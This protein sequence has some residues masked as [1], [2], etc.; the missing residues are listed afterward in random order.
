MTA[1]GVTGGSGLV[2]GAEEYWGGLQEHA[3]GF[4]ERQRC[5]ILVPRGMQRIG[6][7]PVSLCCLF[8]SFEAGSSISI[9]K[10]LVEKKKNKFKTHS[11]WHIQSWYFPL[12]LNRLGCCQ[13]CICSTCFPRCQ[14]AS[15]TIDEKG[16]PMRITTIRQSSK[17]DSKRICMGTGPWHSGRVASSRILT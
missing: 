5:T 9:S 7:F 17:I 2:G 13:T 8:V 6:S 12:S 15:K 4:R 14:Q 1:Y 3:R 10:T 16:Y 11:L